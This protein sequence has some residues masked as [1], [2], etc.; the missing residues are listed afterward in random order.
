MLFFYEF[1]ALSH[2]NLPIASLFAPQFLEENPKIQSF[3]RRDF[4]LLNR[5]GFGV[6]YKNLGFFWYSLNVEDEFLNTIGLGM[7][8]FSIGS[9]IIYLYPDK[10]SFGIGFNRTFLNFN[11]CGYTIYGYLKFSYLCT[12]SNYKNTMFG[13]DVFLQDGF[14][15]EYKFFLD[16]KLN[17]KMGFHIAFAT[18]SNGFAIAYRY[19]YIVFNYFYHSYLGDSFGMNLVYEKN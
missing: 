9:N 15:L 19:K 13:I 12:F 11:L 16:Y 6:S 8:I 3:V 7:N 18:N 10:V 5:Y 4:G 14:D 1:S 17:D 2:Y